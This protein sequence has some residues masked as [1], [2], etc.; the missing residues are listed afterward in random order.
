MFNQAASSYTC[1]KSDTGLNTFAV[2]PAEGLYVNDRLSW[3]FALLPEQHVQ[4]SL[5]SASRTRIGLHPKNQYSRRSIFS[6]IMTVT[7]LHTLIEHHVW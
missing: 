7:S 4:F 2:C 5:I 6:K 1:A 3:Y